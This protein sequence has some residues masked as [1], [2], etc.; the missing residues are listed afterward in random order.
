[1][2]L[3]LTDVYLYI[4]FRIPPTIHSRNQTFTSPTI[5]SPTPLLLIL[6]NIH[7][8]FG[9]QAFSLAARPLLR[10]TFVPR[11]IPYPC[12]QGLEWRKCYFTPRKGVLG[13]RW[14]R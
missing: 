1:M 9:V 7:Q 6:P 5:H 11:H 12:C 10:Q 4:C 13:R 8:Y 3:G 14:S 2:H